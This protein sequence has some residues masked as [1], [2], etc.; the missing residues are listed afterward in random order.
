MHHSNKGILETR[1]NESPLTPGVFVL[2]DEK[3]TK[4]GWLK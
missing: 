3:E 2:L 1:N 4:N